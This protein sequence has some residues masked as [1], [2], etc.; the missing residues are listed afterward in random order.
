MTF[1]IFDIIILT[2]FS[3]SS[4]LGLYRG[5]ISITINLLGFV[6][7][8]LAAIFLYSY[9]RIIFSGYVENEL[10]TSIVS[11]IA[12]YI[13]SLIVFTFLSSKIV[14]LFKPLSQ[15]IFDRLLGFVI[16]MVRGGF[17]SLLIFLVVAIFTAG[18]Y[19]VAERPEE[20]VTKLES[21]KYPEWLKTSMTVPHLERALKATVAYIP[22]SLLDSIEMPKDKSKSDEDI[23]DAIKKKKEAEVKPSEVKSSLEMPLD[24]VLNNSISE[25]LDIN[26]E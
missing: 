11:G 12:S 2:V 23:I 21:E 5:M 1:T 22:K 9:V 15:G 24:N 6:A 19:S 18:T 10:V 17:I 26:E 14:L 8:I 7:S 16:G 13:T 20:M 4:F 25:I 3:A